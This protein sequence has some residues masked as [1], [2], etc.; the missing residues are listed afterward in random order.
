[1]PRVEVDFACVGDSSIQRPSRAQF[2]HRAGFSFFL[3]QMMA[4]PVVHA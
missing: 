2:M 4:E 1:M 3:L